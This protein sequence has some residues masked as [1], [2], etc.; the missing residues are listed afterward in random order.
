MP[1][2]RRVSR[3][4]SAAKDRRVSTGGRRNSIRFSLSLMGRPCLFGEEIENLREGEAEV[5][6]VHTMQPYFLV[7]NHSCCFVVTDPRCGPR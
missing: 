7:S 3:R 2:D 1:K 6:R 4:L 5:N